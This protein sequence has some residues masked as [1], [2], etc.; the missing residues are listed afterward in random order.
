MIPIMATRKKRPGNVFI[1]RRLER[2]AAKVARPQLERHGCH[3]MCGG[4]EKVEQE[5]VMNLKEVQTGRESRDRT[6]LAMSGRSF[7]TPG[8]EAG[9]NAS[10]IPHAPSK[11]AALQCILHPYIRSSQLDAS[12]RTVRRKKLNS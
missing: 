9:A 4:A 5:M 6:A 8:M 10:A 7:T 11:I 2:R 3:S 12:S 1:L